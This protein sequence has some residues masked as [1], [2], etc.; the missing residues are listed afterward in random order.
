MPP[1]LNL[2][3]FFT[4]GVSLAVWDGVGSLDRELALYRRLQSR[5]VKVTFI[6]YG[7]ASELQY[8]KRIPGITICCNRWNLPQ[9]WYERLIPFLHRKELRQA[10]VIKTNQT[11]GADIALAAGRLW[12]KPFLARCGYMWSK[13]LILTHGPD[14]RQANEALAIEKAVFNGADRIAVTTGTMCDSIVDRFP[15]LAGKVAVI[16]NYVDTE[17]FKPFGCSK[18]QRPLLCFVGRLEYEKNLPALL[19]AVDG[20]DVDLQII[21]QGSL[22]DQLTGTWVQKAQV[23]L[24][25]SVPNHRLADH[26]NR[27]TLFVLPSLFEGHPKVLLEAMAC[28]APVLCTDVTGINEVVTHGHNGWLCD[29]DPGSIRAAIVELLADAALREKLGANAAQ[30]IGQNLSLDRIVE[31]ELECYCAAIEG[32]RSVVEEGHA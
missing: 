12:K 14:S 20:L 17:V 24:L 29:T 28:G 10:S 23:R 26:F 3:L 11:P 4:R 6:T 16:P 8:Q 9:R 1:D 21:G 27:C 30:Y 2:A 5:G 15:S 7:D 32:R 31:R 25:G 22:R 19:A 18:P 13:N